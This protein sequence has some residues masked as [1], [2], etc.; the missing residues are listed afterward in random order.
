MDS[1]ACIYTSLAGRPTRIG[2]TMNQEYR[3]NKTCRENHIFLIQI[4]RRSYF[5]IAPF[6]DRAVYSA[7]IIP[8]IMRQLSDLPLYSFPFLFYAASSKNARSLSYFHTLL[9]FNDAMSRRLY[10]PQ[11]DDSFRK[12][13]AHRCNVCCTL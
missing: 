10:Y 8:T 4:Y 11:N 3:K 9:S 12:R 6:I 1:C 2:K 13:T 7:T 5:S